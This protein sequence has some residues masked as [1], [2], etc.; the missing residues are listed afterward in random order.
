MFRCSIEKNIG[1]LE[2]SCDI[3]VKNNRLL[4]ILGPS[5]CGKT[6]LLNLITGIHSPDRGRLS[7]NGT[8]LFDS[9]KQLN[10]PISERHI[11]YIQ[12]SGYLFPH[13]TVKENILYSIPKKKWDHVDVKYRDLL[14]L[15]DLVGHENDHP[16]VLSGGQKQRVAI[17]RALM[18]EP[19][20][21]IWDEP[22]SALDH[23]IRKEMRTLVL[24]VKHEL[25]IPMIFVTHDLDEAFD[26]ADDLAV[27]LKGRILQHGDKMDVIYNPSSKQVETLIG[28]GTKR[29]PFV[30]GVSGLSNSG[31]TTLMEHLIKGL[32]QEGYRVGTIK[33]H[34]GDFNIDE[35]DK[36]S[37]RHRSAGANRV[38]LASQDKYAV[39][40]MNEKENLE[41]DD[42]I[43][44]HMDMD[45]ILFEGYKRSKYKK[46]EVLRKE[47]SENL[48][49]DPNT[50]IGVV[51]DVEI[52]LNCRGI[53]VFD[54]NEQEKV[55]N[56]V[57]Y[58]IKEHNCE[59]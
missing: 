31:K 16:H 1:P 9:E 51:T 47:V 5:G 4:V 8:T 55:L 37:Y 36:D 45:V 19:K 18:M 49:C 21:M 44:E 52:D 30:L 29:K 41:L 10:Q 57:M 59:G 43:K 6:T 14:K 54:M 2:L 35:A 20:L 17:G 25:G 40:S 48:V 12:Q 50:L 38:V 13:L 22:F 23:M 24:K 33:H 42:L 27:M 15:F 7:I 46:I 53:T 28:A 11:G 39:V 34:A 56:E 3:E 26:L 32:R 58:H